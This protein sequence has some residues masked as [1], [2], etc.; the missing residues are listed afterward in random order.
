MTFS[1]ALQHIY[2]AS[3]AVCY[4]YVVQALHISYATLGVVLAMAGIVGGL[5]QG[6][7]GFFERASS[8]LLLGMQDAGLAAA[9][10]LGALAPGLAVF[11][12]ARVLGALV[13]WPQHPVGSAI[14]TRRFPDRRAYAL[15][16]HVAGGSI[17]TATVPLLASALI[18][19]FGWRVA[20]GVF[21]VPLA[22]GG[23]AVARWLRDAPAP[24]EGTAPATRPVPL[25]SLLGRRQVLVA[26]AA[27]T[28]AAGGRGLGALTAYVPAYLR[29]GLH[30]PVITVG[31]VFTVVVMG[32]I[33]GPVMA[34]RLADHFGRRRVLVVVYLLGAASI[35]AFVLVGVTVAY[36]VVAG[37]LVGVFAYAESPLL[38]AVF[39]E[40]ARGSRERAAFG[41][42]FAVAYGVGALWFAVTGF[43]IDRYG[44]EAAFLVMAGSFVVS[45]ILLAVAGGDAAARHEPPAGVV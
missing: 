12:S 27:G 10:G 2:P 6:A 4:P 41:L 26:L 31:I 32:S 42:Y 5:L 29:S 11:G 16:W 17:G 40:A 25:R 43:V 14:L 3:L 21:A 34:G 7:A 45:S 37:F 20:L 36:L 35:S 23:L 9:T 39:S 38:Q 33:I 24:S 44:F 30:L 1:H 22:I 28:I 13:S 19:A 8:R 15:S 18:A